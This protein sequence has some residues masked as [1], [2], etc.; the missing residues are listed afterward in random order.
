MRSFVP[1][2]PPQVNFLALAQSEDLARAAREELWNLE[3]GEGGEEVEGA[4][5]AADLDRQ[6]AAIRAIDSDARAES[7]VNKVC[8]VQL[9]P[10]ICNGLRLSPHAAARLCKRG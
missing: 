6:R 4:T 2:L 7:A 8:V 9:P 1:S 3:P 5:H 10:R